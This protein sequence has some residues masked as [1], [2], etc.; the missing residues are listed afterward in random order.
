[1]EVR[2]YVLTVKHDDGTIKISTWAS[3]DA[4]VTM[5]LNAERCPRRSILSVKEIPD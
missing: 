4:A 5:I 3:Y 2:R 1:M